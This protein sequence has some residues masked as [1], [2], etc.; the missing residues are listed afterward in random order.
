MSK[1]R[2]KVCGICTIADANKA[3]N[4]GVDAIGM[5]FYAK[6][7]RNVTVKTAMDI[8]SSLPPFVSSVG[9]FVNSDQQEVK[10]VLTHVQ[11]DLLQFHGDED[12]AFCSSFNRPYIKVVRVTRDTDLA[13]I[14]IRYAS[15]RG[16]LLDSYKEGTPGGTGEAF[17]WGMIPNDL[18]LPV[19]LA[20]GLTPENVAAAVSRVQPWAVDVSS[21]VEESPGKKDAYKIEQFIHAVK[22]VKK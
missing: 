2:I 19:I 14:C 18:S 12:E 8:V 11:L 10:Q 17:D 7:P 21:G 5:V 1:T 4:A 6:S 15:A 20:G 22:G 3:C 9:L 13:S 16:V